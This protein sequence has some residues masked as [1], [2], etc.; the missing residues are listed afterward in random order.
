MRILVTENDRILANL[1]VEFLQD[2]GHQVR[3]CDR[4]RASDLV[5]ATAWDAWI[6]DP[7]GSS[8][9]E[10]DSDCASELRRL[11]AHVPI[12]VTTGRAWAQRTPPADLRVHAILPK[13]YDLTDLQRALAAISTPRAGPSPCAT[14]V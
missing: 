9:L 11:A 12:V 4:Q 7:D 1:L 5:C 8:F 3:V 14:E 13:P 6:V 2:E 10:L